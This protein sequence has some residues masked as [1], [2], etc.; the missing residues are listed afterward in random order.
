MS[1]A[2]L[3]NNN[4]NVT[5][6][7][8]S[9]SQH[10]RA[11]RS[12]GFQ[13]TLQN[14]VPNSLDFRSLQNFNF[15]KD[16]QGIWIDNS[17]NSQ[18]TTITTTAGQTFSVPAGY[19]GTSWLAVNY[20]TPVF[21]LTGSGTVSYVMTNFPLPTAV[22]PASVTN[23]GTQI[24]SDPALEALITPEGL[25]VTDGL[26]AFSNGLGSIT[27]SG[28][29]VASLVPAQLT[30]GG[31]IKNPVEAPASLFVDAVNTAGT[32]TPGPNYT[33]IELQPGDE[34]EIPANAGTVTAN[35]TVSGHTF[36]SI[37]QTQQ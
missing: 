28:T 4:M 31:Y 24:V 26:Y 37:G 27:T 10:P 7:N 11:S 30:G 14:G 34:I 15:M 33:T 29:A 13:A 20:E 12:Y 22:W 19:Q 35:S 6:T 3:A 23:G 16:V 36:V 5:T 2:N 32:V 18:P 25:L 1:G 9:N 21:T 8:T 17:Q